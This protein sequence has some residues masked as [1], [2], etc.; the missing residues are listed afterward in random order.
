[1]HRHLLRLEFPDERH[2]PLPFRSALQPVVI[3]PQ[4]RVGIRRV[5]ETEGVGDEVRAND[6]RPNNVRS[7]LV[8]WSSASASLTTSQT[9][10]ASLVPPH[11]GV[12]VIT[13]P[14]QQFLP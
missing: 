5:R 2:E 3:V 10:T 8:P 12:D 6:L 4:D 14:L 11:H 9:F 13:H 1:M 7:T